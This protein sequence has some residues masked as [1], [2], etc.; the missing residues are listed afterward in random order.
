MGNINK[1]K[2]MNGILTRAIMK[3]HNDFFKMSADEQDIFKLSEH[4]DLDKKIRKFVV[5]ELGFKRKTKNEMEILEINKI[6]LPYDGIGKDSFM[7]NEWDWDEKIITYGNLY[8]YN[9]A[10]HKQ[11]EEFTE[12]DTEKF[13]ATK[14]YNRFSSWARVFINEEFYYV[15]LYSLDNW[16]FWDLENFWFEWGQEQL[17][18]KY[19][20]GKNDGKKVAGGY[21]WDKKLDAGGLEGWYDQL[22]KFRADYLFAKIKEVRNIDDKV[23]IFETT[24]TDDDPS[25]DYIFGSMNVLKNITFNNFVD[26]CEKSKGNNDDIMEIR[27]KEVDKFKDAL[28]LELEKI[29]KTAPNVR[30]L[31][32]NKIIMAE[33]ALDDL[34]KLS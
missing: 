31:K 10:Y 9:E 29:K 16:I 7:L 5:Q 11:Q 13:R 12:Q 17:P 20:S 3:Y 23:Y 33:S 2:I 28:T 18:H 25:K 21:S 6:M 15:N 8:E 34:D 22:N 19:V 24:E 1:D 14:L 27:N 30:T 32:T 4:S 26:D